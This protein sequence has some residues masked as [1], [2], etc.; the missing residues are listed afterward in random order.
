MK[1]VQVI[2]H[3]KLNEQR[4]YW[5]I[6]LVFVTVATW[7]VMILTSYWSMNFDNMV[8]YDNDYYKSYKGVNLAWLVFGLIYIVLGIL[9]FHYNLY[10]L[11]T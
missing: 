2:Y 5:T 10:I 4:N 1:D 11:L 6:L 9:A 3:N 8:E 7:P